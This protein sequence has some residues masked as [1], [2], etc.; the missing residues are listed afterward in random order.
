MNGETQTRPTVNSQPVV[1][2]AVLKE[3]KLG[4]EEKMFCPEW[5]PPNE[6]IPEDPT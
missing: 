6:D 4:T 2:E 5:T 3:R 1:E